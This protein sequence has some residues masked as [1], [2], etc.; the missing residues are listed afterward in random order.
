M[1]VRKFAANVFSNWTHVGV[2]LALA[3]FITPIIL[4]GLGREMYGVWTFV[5]QA[6]GFFTVLDLGVNTA[7]VRFIS[8]FEAKGEH[9][10]AR[11]VFST[12]LLLFSG[13]ALVAIS[14]I[15][16]LAPVLARSVELTTTPRRTVVVVLMLVGGEIAVGLVLSVYQATL[17]ALQQF[18]RLNAIMIVVRLIKNGLIVW[19]LFS[20]YSIL[21]MALVQVGTTLLRLFLLW[22]PVRKRFRF[23]RNDPSRHLVG[24][25]TQYSIYS[26]LI[27]IVLKAMFYTYSLVIS[28]AI[29]ADQVVFFDIPMLILLHTEIVVYSMMSVLTP[30]ISA[31]EA[32]DDLG[33][34]RK[35]FLYGTRYALGLIL[36]MMLALYAHGHDFI[37]LWQG[38]AI[39]ETAQPVLQVLVFGFLFYLAQLI[40]NSVLKGVSRHRVYSFLLLGAAI[41]VV[42][43]SIPAAHRFGLEGIAAATAIPLA[44]VCFFA[45][46][47]YTCY[48]LGLSYWSYLKGCWLRPVL[49][50][51]PPVAL[52]LWRPLEVDSYFVFLSYCAA[53]QLYFL[54]AFALGVVEP[55]HRQ[56]ILARFRKRAAAPTT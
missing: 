44:L 36:P 35:I 39:G 24:E 30:V 47:A 50:A 13:L 7:I 40:C 6:A 11:A 18:V 22:L 8:R 29:H 49:V 5:V 53:L 45:V 55:E 52:H 20:G 32:R 46:P 16:L 27:T 19:L 28:I 48:V 21:A 43:T 34:N 37:R 56:R 3:F 23:R 41:G 33:A 15:A 1:D 54:V 17:K 10:R 4:K 9:Q 2:K 12:G 38:D 26:F 25:L 31:N 14:A 51:I 42:A